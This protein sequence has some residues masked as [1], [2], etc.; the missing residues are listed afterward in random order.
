MVFDIIK[1]VFLT[2]FR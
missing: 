1:V 2:I